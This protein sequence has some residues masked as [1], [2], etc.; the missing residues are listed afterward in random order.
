MNNVYFACRE[1]R[2]Y[3]DAG[4]R[5]AY[6][7]LEKQGTVSQGV[8]VK[9]DCL[10]SA[11]SYWKPEPNDHNLWLTSVLSHAKH[12]ILFHKAHAI[13]YGDLERVM[14]TE[15]DEYEQFSWMN[16]HPARETDLRPRN[17]VEQLGMRTWGEVTAYLASRPEKPWWYL[18]PSARVAARRKFDELILLGLTTRRADKP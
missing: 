10:L 3:T 14:G 8:V 16:E 5:W 12:F 13:V 11:D 17:F 4:Y 18:L 9:V 15:A 6:S 2:T 1:C 7:Q